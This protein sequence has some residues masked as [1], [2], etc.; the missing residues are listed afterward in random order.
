MEFL[1]L[2]HATDASFLSNARKVFTKTMPLDCKFKVI[3]GDFSLVLGTIF[4]KP[5]KTDCDVTLYGVVKFQRD[6]IE[7]LILLYSPL[8]SSPGF[9]QFIPRIFDAWHQVFF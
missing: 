1:L 6:S 2:L 3:Y 9:P 5:T 8:S 4:T 7:H